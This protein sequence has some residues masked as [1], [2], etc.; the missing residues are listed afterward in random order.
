MQVGALCEEEEEEK[1]KPVVIKTT[2]IFLWA[3]GPLLEIQFTT[4]NE[5]EGER[6]RELRSSDNIRVKQRER[7]STGQWSER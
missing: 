4:N 2:A 3:F 1:L 6:E 7:E 5:D